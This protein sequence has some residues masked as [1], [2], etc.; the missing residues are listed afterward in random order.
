MVLGH[1]D[2]V[3]GTVLQI[4]PTSAGVLGSSVG[5]YRQH[6]QGLLTIAQ[7][8]TGCHDA[9]PKFGLAFVHLAKAAWG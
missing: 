7:A 6:I 9:P 3:V 4:F 5:I 1:V 8:G 2:R